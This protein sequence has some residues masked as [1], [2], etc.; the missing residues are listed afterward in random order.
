MIAISFAGPDRH[1]DFLGVEEERGGQKRASVGVCTTT[2]YCCCL[3]WQRDVQEVGWKKGETS[4]SR[5]AC[6]GYSETRGE[7]PSWSGPLQ[8]RG[9]RRG[10]RPCGESWASISV[11]GM[12]DECGEGH[13]G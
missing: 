13:A 6:A 5:G 4:A 3:S 11:C 2:Y 9:K 7:R 8:V 1:S 10:D 12:R